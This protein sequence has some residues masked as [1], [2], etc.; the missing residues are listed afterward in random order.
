MVERIARRSE[1]LEDAQ[2]R[3]IL[4]KPEQRSGS[5]PDESQRPPLRIVRRYHRL[6]GLQDEPAGVPLGE[7]RARSLAHLGAR[8]ARRPGAD[9]VWRCTARL[10]RARL[11]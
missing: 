2:R 7:T 5:A 8:R 6:F 10:C 4:A 9:L 1:G 11:E 3:S